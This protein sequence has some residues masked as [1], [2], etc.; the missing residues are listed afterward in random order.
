MKTI[1]QIKTTIVLAIIFILLAFTIALDKLHN[2][3]FQINISEAK[4]P[5]T[6]YDE[7]KF[8]DGKVWC[9]DQAA[10]KMQLKWMRYEIVKD[11]TYKD[12]DIDVEY[13]EILATTK[14][15]KDE[16]F[17]MKCVID[18]YQ[19]EGTMRLLKAEKEKKAWSFTGK[20]KVKPEKKK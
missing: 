3:D 11:S 2:R 9:G 18:N 14:L 4:K 5:K 8:K 12:E 6:T 15:G 17:E 13:L 1:K 16:L 7:M 19:I 10:E 20:E